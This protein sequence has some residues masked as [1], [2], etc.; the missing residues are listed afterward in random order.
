MFDFINVCLLVIDVYYIRLNISI[1]RN[2]DQILLENLYGEILLNESLN[3]EDT[4]QPAHHK[5]IDSFR[6]YWTKRGVRN[7]TDFHYKGTKYEHIRPSE[8]E[9]EK[10]DRNKGLGTS[11]MEDLCNFADNLGV[12]IRLNP[13][14]EMGATSIN[15]LEKFYKRFGFVENKPGKNKDYSISER[16]YR[17]P[18]PHNKK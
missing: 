3:G 15:R 9:I 17:N 8:I 18:K 6:E 14:D 10:K 5:S 16:F 11:F 2:A 7:M 4:I 13:S 12:Q 1:M